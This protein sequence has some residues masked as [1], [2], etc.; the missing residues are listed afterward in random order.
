MQRSSIDIEIAELI[1]SLMATLLPV[2]AKSFVEWFQNLE[3][4]NLCEGTKIIATPSSPQDLSDAEVSSSLAELD[5]LSTL[6]LYTHECT[7]RRNAAN[8]NT[9]TRTM[10]HVVCM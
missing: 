5:K 3:E 8:A 10:V 9:G 2:D 6:E 7:N 4:I 1:E